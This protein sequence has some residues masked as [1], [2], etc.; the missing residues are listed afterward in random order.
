MMPVLWVET[1]YQYRRVL[2]DVFNVPD[3]QA[4]IVPD[5]SW[6]TWERT[7]HYPEYGIKIPAI[8]MDE[9]VVFNVDPNDTAQYTEALKKGIAHASSTA[10]PDNGGLGYYFAHSS[11]G[12]LRLQN[13]AV[14]YLL[15][16]LKEGDKVFIW[17]DGKSFEYRV[18][19]Q[20]VNAPGETEFLY[21]KYEEETIVLQT[22]WPPG[23]TLQ[24]ML[25]FAKRV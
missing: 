10:F 12:E 5:F 18:I 17:H 16:K 14:F 1:K 8:F 22:C 11:S 9:P 7:T 19:E 20:R 13:N 6:F 4:L 23:S 15:G 21:Q 25:V 24:R 3:L 2:S